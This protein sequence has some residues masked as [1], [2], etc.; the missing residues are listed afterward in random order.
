MMFFPIQMQAEGSS[1]RLDFD[2]TSMII[3]LSEQPKLVT[4]NGYLVLKTSTRSVTLSLPCKV[5]PIGSSNTDIEKVRIR[6]N[7]N[8]RISVFTI[9]GKRITTLDNINAV[10]YL[11]R[12]IYIINGKKVL[13]Q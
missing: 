6:N 3:E 9:D 5:T 1:L 8:T 4:E 13:I 7:S 10:Q 2:G 11:E 12:G